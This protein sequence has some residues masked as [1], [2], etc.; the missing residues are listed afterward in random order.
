MER[1]SVR[2]ADAKTVGLQDIA[3][4]LGISIGTVDRALHNRPGVNPMTRSKVVQM[5][6]TLGY[7]RNLAASFLASRKRL[8]IGVVLPRKPDLFFGRVTEGIFDAARAY[9]G[10]G[11]S[12][13]YRPSP[14]LK[15]GE[16]EAVERVLDDGVNALIVAPGTPDILRALIR[17]ASRMNVPVVCVATDAPGT[18]RLT[19]VAADPAT[20]GSMA[21]DL[22]GGLLQGTGR[23]AVIT[24]SLGTSTHTESLEGFRATIS[25]LYPGMELSA[26][27]EAHD[28][29]MEAYNKS[30]EIL[31]SIPEL[32]GIYVGTSTSMPVLRALD[33]AGLS[34]K[35]RVIAMDL[36]PELADR[37]EAG[38]VFASI[39]QRPRNQGRLAMQ[40]LY[41]FL[42]E[43]V[44]PPAQIRFPATLVMR[45]NLELF[46]RI[47]PD[48]EPP[49]EWNDASTVT[50][51]AD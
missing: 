25:R 10:A 13:E 7:R 20:S 46:L 19:S 1:S 15:E 17:K 12:V 40:A 3:S 49:G 31:T 45:G 32:A 50:A 41:R 38:H 16:A 4:A 43:G 8:R 27:V 2:P 34:G 24:G 9:E 29:E 14:W 22:L 47:L 23:V 51:A 6:R 37:I 21:A 42:S 39:Y 18:E 44:C 5:A 33:E 11:I 30:L 36:F 48:R 28:D 35:V 26:A